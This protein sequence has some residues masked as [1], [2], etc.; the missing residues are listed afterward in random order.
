MSQLFQEFVTPEQRKLAAMVE[1]WGGVSVLENQQAMRELSDAELAITAASGSDNRHGGVRP[2]GVVELQLEIES[3]PN[4]TIEKNAEFFSRK[5]EIQRRQIAEDI[6]RADKREGDRIVSVVTAAP[7]DR[8]VDPVW[9]FQATARAN[10]YPFHL[11]Y[12]QHMER[13]GEWLPLLHHNA[14]PNST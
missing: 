2:F 7:H 1:Q 3:D 11:G 9:Q 4:E 10:S 14:S 13:Y 6:A 8:I 5:F 12:L